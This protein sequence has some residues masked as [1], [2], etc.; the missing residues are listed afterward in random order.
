MKKGSINFGG[1]DVDGIPD[2]INSAQKSY[3]PNKIYS[4]ENDRS[5]ELSRAN[6]AEEEQV[7]TPPVLSIN[8]G[9]C[10][11]LCKLARK[12]IVNITMRAKN[13][14]SSSNHRGLGWGRNKMT[15][16]KNLW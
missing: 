3:K 12:M 8:I 14:G 11:V 7:T 5:Y 15:Y 2:K 13:Q 6:S 16:R 1:K 9:K 4:V 10:G